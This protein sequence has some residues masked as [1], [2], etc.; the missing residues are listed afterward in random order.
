MSSGL[1]LLG[2]T[3]L[4]LAVAAGLLQAGAGIGPW[5]AQPAATSRAGRLVRIGLVAQTVSLLAALVVLAW[6]LAAQDLT[7]AYVVHHSHRAMPLVYRLAAVWGGHEGSLLLW[8][9]LLAGWSAVAAWGLRAAEPA[10]ANRVLAVLGAL[11]LGL[12]AL[13]LGGA[14]PFEAWQG[15]AALREGMGLNPLLQDPAMALH[16]PLLY[17][18][19]AGTALPFAMTLATLAWG[20][21]A[22]WVRRSRPFTAAALACLSVGIALGSWWS[23]YELGWGG[24]WFWDPVENASLLPWLALAALLHV[25]AGRDQRGRFAHASALLAMA[26]WALALLG[27][28]LVRSGVLTSVHAFASDPLRGSALLGLMALT[29][30]VCFVL[31]ARHPERLLPAKAAPLPAVVSRESVLALNNLLLIVACSSVALGT[32]YPLAMEVLGL[33]RLSVGAPYFERVLGPLLGLAL[34]LL[35]PAAWLRWG[36]SPWREL[37]TRL[38]PVALLMALGAVAVPL[39]LWGVFGRWQWG[40]TLALWLALGVAGSTL[41]WAWQRMRSVGWRGFGV[42]PGGMVMAHLGV[43]VFTAGVALSN[44]YG[45]ERDVRLAPGESAALAGCPL[46]F[47]GLHDEIGPNYLARVGQFRWGCEGDVPRLLR[48]EKR[49]YIGGGRPTTEAAIAPGL[50][51]DL[52]VAMGEPLGQGL[53]AS[54]SLR[55][56]HKPGVRW[57]WAGALLMA[58]GAALSALARRG[59]LL[60]ASRQEVPA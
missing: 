58:A 16:P 23:Y 27:T 5:L 56:Q 4:W 6:A 32:L 2:N 45:H 31:Y 48:A 49:V 50:W 28:F 47:E 11:S 19:Y 37:L 57:I 34:A 53:S 51:R 7:I 60:P 20:A 46:T 18:G 59:P 17:L 22:D 3:L 26:A 9:G 52:Y 13:L 14:N 43:A 55:V 41:A 36:A 12:L 39:L 44:G 29:L 42:S 54:W 8:A 24:W 30:L 25:Q 38:R 40:S 10:W 21:P 33:G 15:A 35:V 1:G